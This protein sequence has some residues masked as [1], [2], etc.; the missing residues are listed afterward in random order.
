MIVCMCLYKIYT[1]VSAISL[2]SLQK[3]NISFLTFID[4]SFFSLCCHCTC[5]HQLFLVLPRIKDEWSMVLMV[6]NFQNQITSFELSNHF[7]EFYVI[8]LSTDSQLLLLFFAYDCSHLID[9]LHFCLY[10]ILLLILDLT[11]LNLP[12]KLM[13]PVF[14][15]TLSITSDGSDFS[16]NVTPQRGH[17]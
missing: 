8:I 5:G 15:N 16:V 11:H 6:V 10:L 17:P 12:P 7:F 1:Y 4:W 2:N 13:L 14:W 3:L 9:V